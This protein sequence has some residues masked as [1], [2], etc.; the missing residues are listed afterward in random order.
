MKPT[1]LS[2]GTAGDVSLNAM[3]LPEELKSPR[4]AV[5]TRPLVQGGPPAHDLKLDAGR[6][7]PL[8]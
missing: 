2:D 7:R 4:E 5:P 3:M 8:S 6:P 1:G